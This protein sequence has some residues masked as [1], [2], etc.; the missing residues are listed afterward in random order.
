MTKNERIK[1]L[2]DNIQLLQQGMLASTEYIN[3]RFDKIS[4]EKNQPELIE[5]PIGLDK[6]R[7]VVFKDKRINSDAFFVYFIDENIDQNNINRILI[8]MKETK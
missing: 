8:E 6:H 5:V 7:H 4:K 3:D 2:E 1:L